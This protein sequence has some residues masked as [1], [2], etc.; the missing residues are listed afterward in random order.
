[1]RICLGAVELHYLQ[2]NRGYKSLLP[3]ICARE[4]IEANHKLMLEPNAAAGRLDSPV[5][6]DLEEAGRL[7]GCDFLVNVV[8]NSKKQIVKAVA[9]DPIAAHREGV[10]VV[11]SMY[12]IPITEAC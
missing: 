12:I 7:I 2:D 3:G 1:M 11:D 9:G 4:T 8:L 10:K 5:R 6:E